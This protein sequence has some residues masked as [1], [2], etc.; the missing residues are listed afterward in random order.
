MKYE[1]LDLGEVA[2]RP[3][4]VYDVRFLE[5]SITAFPGTATHPF[6]L[7]DMARILSLDSFNSEAFNRL[8]IED[9]LHTG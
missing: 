7:N 4:I 9:P 1:A 6:D 5:N 8:L 3:S 2:I